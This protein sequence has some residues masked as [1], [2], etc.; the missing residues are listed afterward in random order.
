MPPW[1]AVPGY[2]DFTGVR[3]LSPAE[4]ATVVVVGG[5]AADPAAGTV[6]VTTAAVTAADAVK[7]IA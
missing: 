2:G 3:R 5:A 1:K 6:A 7:L 4:I